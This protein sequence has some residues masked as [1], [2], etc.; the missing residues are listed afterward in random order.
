MDAGY[1]TE[2]WNGKDNYGRYVPTGNY[3]YSIEQNRIIN[4][5]KMVLL[6]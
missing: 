4:N 1:S 6:R 3:L 2:L 5:K